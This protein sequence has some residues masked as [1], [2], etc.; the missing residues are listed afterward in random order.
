MPIAI[1]KELVPKSEV[2]RFGCFIATSGASAV[3]NVTTRWV[4]SFVLVYEV[5]V[6]L[7]YLVG[8]VTAFLLARL[9]VFEG[10]TGSM[11]GQFIR[12][13]LVNMIGFTQVWLI[14]VGLVRLVFPAL[15]SPPNAETTAHVIGL[16][17][18]AVTSY[19]LHKRFSFRG[20]GP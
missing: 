15:G 18:L 17:S 7:A 13:A 9:F 8:M 2:V 1:R 6:A 3:I 16:A 4:L 20:A 14:S 12:F 5:T 11:Q 19:L 10:D